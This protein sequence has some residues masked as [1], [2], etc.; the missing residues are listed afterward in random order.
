MPCSLTDGYVTQ[1][2]LPSSLHLFGFV[3]IGT[4][5]KLKM[6][7]MYMENITILFLIYVSSLFI[8]AAIFYRMYFGVTDLGTVGCCCSYKIRSEVTVHLGHYSACQE[9]WH[10]YETQMF[11]TILL[12]IHHLMASK[13]S[14]HSKN[15][16]TPNV[17]TCNMS[18]F[19][20]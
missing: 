11:I 8:H 20:L 4:E 5:N 14:Y 6:Q 10:F 1:S 12:C 17:I 7:F 16:F 3:S 2:I 15:Q 19:V 9:S 18:Y 13:A